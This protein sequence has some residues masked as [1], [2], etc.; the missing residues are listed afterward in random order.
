MDEPRA[1]K[2]SLVWPIVVVLS[3]ASVP[4]YVLSIGPAIYLLNAGA[5]S[6]QPVEV[7]YGPLVWAAEHCG[8]L[9]YV[10][11]RY[12]ALWLG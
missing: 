8:P 7:F 4:L 5:V 1:N 11:K 3:L 10:L 9:D 12:I 2:S 6:R